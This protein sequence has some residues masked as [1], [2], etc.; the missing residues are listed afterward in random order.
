MNTVQPSK[1]ARPVKRP[2]LDAQA[3]RALAIAYQVQGDARA[4][5]QM[6]EGNQ[7][8]VVKQA[9]KYRQAGV[10]T[11]ELISVGNLGLI[12]S[13]DKFDPNKGV[14]FSTYAVYWI[15][16]EMERF[17][18]KSHHSMHV[19][20]ASLRDARAVSKAE[21]ELS[22]ASGR[23]ASASEVAQTLGW[24]LSRVRTVREINNVQRMDWGSDQ[25]RE[26]VDSVP[27]E[28]D[29]IEHVASQEL[30]E[31][32]QEALFSLDQR[33]QDVVSRFYGLRGRKLETQQ[34]IADSH[35]LTARQVRTI[36]KRALSLLETQLAGAEPI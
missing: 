35:G 11:E 6:I 13:I 8:L 1:R 16:Y 32:L 28:T 4:R 9:M 27:D 25:V 14:A 20:E 22:Q 36:L 19:P 2:V 31:Q 12:R 10:S 21:R 34:A 23:E 30:V 3:N 18:L 17:L 15:Q 5:D 24:D 26:L 29:L 33:E 7:L